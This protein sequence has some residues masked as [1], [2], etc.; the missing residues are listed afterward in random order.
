MS[1]LGYDAVGVGNADVQIGEAFYENAAANKL[2]VLD[3]SPVADKRSVPYVVN[4]AGGVRVGIISF[5]V[6]RADAKINEY[7][8]RKRR[9]EAYK[10]VRS[11]CD[12]LIVLDQA[13]VTT[14]DWLQ[15]NAVRLGAPDIVIPGT[16][17]EFLSSAKTVGGTHIM[18][19]LY[20]AK[21]MGLVDVEFTPGEPPKVAFSR[22]M[23]DEK[24]AE[25]QQ[26][27]DRVGKAIV[28]L[29]MAPQ[30]QVAPQ[31]QTV[32]APD[33]KP[34]Y[35][36]LL[37]KVC[38]QR[39]YEDWVLTKHAKALKTLVNVRNTTPDCLPCHS[40]QYRASK[41][42]VV[43]PD[44]AAGVE[45]ATCH[46]NTLPHGMERENMAM[47]V[48]V[49]PKLCLE[50]HTK[51]RSPT[52]DEKTYFPKVVHAAVPPSTTASNPKTAQ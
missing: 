43:L 21:E 12:V 34:Y 50:C 20:Q 7:E 22:V 35:S 10:Q 16:S 5:G 52:Y 25:D 36:P 2:T 18:P 30:P 47:H 13:F 40:E 27:A 4:D 8:L 17:R 31:M 19:A 39:Q 29:G 24:F 38:H 23:L 1:Q 42:Y 11:K 51:D 3:A 41:R 37:C 46:T 28:A 45:C 6:M 14:E 26:V 49:D 44:L 33:V 48:K 15:R 32:N 9:F